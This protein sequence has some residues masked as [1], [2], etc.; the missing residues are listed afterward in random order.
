M[1]NTLL[2]VQRFSPAV[3]DPKRHLAA[4][5]PALKL[6]GRKVC[7]RLVLEEL[8]HLVAR[9][10]QRI[11]KVVDGE[12]PIA[13]NL[14]Q[15]ITTLTYS[16][17]DV[18]YTLFPSTCMLYYLGIIAG[19]HYKRPGRITQRAKNGCCDNMKHKRSYTLSEHTTSGQ[20]VCILILVRWSVFCMTFCNISPCPNTYPCSQQ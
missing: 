7:R 9:G 3:G 6:H 4:A 13:G 16:F 19:R 2:R 10:L 1:Q 8:V 14:P 20:H 5:A 11:E 12:S 18:P 17:V 15:R